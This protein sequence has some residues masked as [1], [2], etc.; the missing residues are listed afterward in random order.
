M[1]IKFTWTPDISVGDETIDRQHQ[2]LLDEL[3]VLLGVMMGEKR[4]EFSNV[5]LFLDMYIKN[6]FSYEEAYMEEMGFPERAAHKKSHEHFTERYLE[7]KNELEKTGPT[8]KLI[9]D[10]ENYIGGWWLG[11]IG[12]EDR[13]YYLFKEEQKRASGT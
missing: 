4:V 9:L 10:V 13:Q 3:N 6:H 5:L 11:H 2:Q 1:E 12:Q 7:F 8:E